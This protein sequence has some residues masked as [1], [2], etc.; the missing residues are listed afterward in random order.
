LLHPRNRFQKS[1]LNEYRPD[2]SIP[3]ADDT[4]PLQLRL[5][6]S[7]VRDDKGE[8]KMKSKWFAAISLFVLFMLPV[9]ALHAQPGGEAVNC[10]SRN[11]SFQRCDVP[12]RDARLIR[13]LS[14]TQCIRGQN[15][16]IDR[17]G[18]WVDRGCGGTFVP[19]G[20]GGGPNYGGP[21]GPGGGPGYWQPGPGWDSRFSIAC[22]SDDY[23][24][25]FCGVDA[26]GGGRVYVERQTS[27]TACIEGRTWG[28]NRAGVWVTGGCAA[29]FT[30]DRRWR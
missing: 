26:G 13:Q 6:L 23:N 11:Y 5:D 8:F 21:G 30:I 18:L 2:F 15:W 10:E 29:V 28:W 22:N 17:A 16:G 9:A 3:S 14:G 4:R 20:H 25:R 7:R 24:Y 1:A 27:N 12:W 19:G